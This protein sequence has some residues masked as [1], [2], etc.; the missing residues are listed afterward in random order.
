M[1]VLSFECVCVC[2][3]GVRWCGGFLSF[4]GGGFLVFDNEQRASDVVG[5]WF[6]DSALWRRRTYGMENYR[7]RATFLPY[8]S[9]CNSTNVRYLHVAEEV[10]EFSSSDNGYLLYALVID[11][12]INAFLSSILV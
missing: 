2:V 10:R 5:I 7:K 8:L 6:Y 3:C 4:L 12:I 11:D 9:F 1:V